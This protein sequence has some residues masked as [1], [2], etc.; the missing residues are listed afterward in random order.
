[1]HNDIN[2]QELVQQIW[3][4]DIECTINNTSDLSVKVRHLYTLTTLAQTIEMAIQ[5]EFYAPYIQLRNQ[6][7]DLLYNDKLYIKN[8][9]EIQL[10]NNKN[11]DCRIDFITDTTQPDI[12][13]YSVLSKPKLE[14]ESF[15]D[16][17]YIDTNIPIDYNKVK[18][19]IL[20]KND[21]NKYYK[22]GVKVS[23]SVNTLAHRY[24]PT[25][26]QWSIERKSEEFMIPPPPFN[27]F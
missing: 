15:V 2:I 19:T 8:D 5:H 7:G 26:K 22:I 18:Q 27:I 10:F 12:L 6:T 24:D 4:P 20:R 13:Y 11:P 21:F 17:I 14:E 16:H 9:K 23:F 3:S 1:M 25:Q